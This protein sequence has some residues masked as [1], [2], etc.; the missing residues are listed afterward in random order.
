MQIEL[1][2]S[3]GCGR[4]GETAALLEEL[5]LDLDRADIHWRLVDV[6]EELDYAVA[7]GVLATP[8]IAIGG[9]LVHTGAPG[10]R[11]LRELIEEA[12]DG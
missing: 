6:I 2:S 4:C 3:P 5:V 10:R 1:F 11:R 7:L 12:G 8:A 9:R